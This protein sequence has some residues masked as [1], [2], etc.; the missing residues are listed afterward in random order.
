M[1]HVDATSEL[2]D[3]ADLAGDGEWRLVMCS[4]AERK[5]K[6]WANAR[7]VSEQSLPDEP[8]AMRCFY[9]LPTDGG[10]QA[11]VAVAAGAA[12]SSS[13]AT[14]GRFRAP[15]AL[16]VHDAVPARGAAGD[17]CGSSGEGAA[18]AAVDQP[19]PSSPARRGAPLT[20]RTLEFLAIGDPDSE[21]GNDTREVSARRARFARAHGASGPPIRRT[22]VTAL[23]VIKHVAD[24]VDATSRLVFC[25]EHGQVHVLSADAKEVQTTHQLPSA[26]AFV[27]VTT[28]AA[29]RA[30]TSSRARAATIGATSLGTARWTIR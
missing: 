27:A 2:M 1:A 20:E 11:G 3:T 17:R 8:V 12:C 14:A 23:A 25:T 4:G 9:A 30:S 6:V 29:R 22:S 10:A 15:A 5:I 26:V 16:Q 19:S 18:D 13:A 7:L 21:N 28:G 24:D